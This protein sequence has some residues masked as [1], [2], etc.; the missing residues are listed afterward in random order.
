ME[1]RFVV[2]GKPVGKGRPRFSTASGYV[3]TYTPEKTANYENWVKLCYQDIWHGA[4]LLEGPLCMLL[5]ATFEVPK[6]WPKKRRALAI[7]G[8]LRPVV[9]PDADNL[10]KAVADALNGI[11]YQDD[12]QVVSVTCHKQY[13]TAAGL[14]V[15]L[16]TLDEQEA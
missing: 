16:R 13:G 1:R 15:S 12:V 2:P 8:H 3:K 11:A 6:S 14:V 9:K 4:P 5:E 10:I 7:D